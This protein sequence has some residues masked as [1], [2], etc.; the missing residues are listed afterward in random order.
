M[1]M[2]KSLL[3]DPSL[4]YCVWYIIQVEDNGTWS[5]LRKVSQADEYEVTDIPIASNA[6]DYRLAIDIEAELHVDILRWKEETLTRIT[7]EYEIDLEYGDEF[8]AYFLQKVAESDFDKDVKKRI[9][10]LSLREHAV[11]FG[12][13]AVI[14]MVKI[15]G[16]E[17]VAEFPVLLRM[18]LS[19][20]DLVEALAIIERGYGELLELASIDGIK[21]VADAGIPP[22][23]AVGFLN[24]YRGECEL[25]V[26]LYE[27]NPDWI[28]KVMAEPFV[29][30]FG[31]E[32]VASVGIEKVDM[33]VVLFAAVMEATSD[34]DVENEIRKFLSLS[35]VEKE[36]AI[37]FG[38]S[39]I[40]WIHKLDIPLELISDLVGAGVGIFPEPDMVRIND[41][42]FYVLPRM[43]DGA[44]EL[45][46][47]FIVQRIPGVRVDYDVETLPELPVE[48][49]A[50]IKTKH[51]YN[52]VFSFEDFLEHRADIEREADPFYTPQT[53]IR[54]TPKMEREDGELQV[55]KA[56]IPIKI[57]KKKQILELIADITITIYRCAYGDSEVLEQIRNAKSTWF[58]TVP[59][60]E[61]G[62]DVLAVKFPVIEFH[63][64]PPVPY[65]YGGFDTP[66]SGKWGRT[67]ENDTILFSFDAR[68]FTNIID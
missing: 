58:A 5:V 36:I 63:L 53:F 30:I 2:F 33:R 21:A 59:L 26:R 25:L 68:W 50:V 14:E 47:G 12:P 42:L 35:D 60:D 20:E 10:E 29:D 16:I 11:G 17:I 64:N 38:T 3:F 45:R 39:S 37:T 61:Y 4:G 28:T 18:M 41:K 40:E 32:R 51:G 24:R 27:L 65:W 1:F 9:I 43:F 56:S 66:P 49:L 55:L 22:D 31:L 48:P 54:V 8:D 34:V 52:V 6:E 44:D 19:K 62:N 7:A 13:E 46:G 23:I 15:A 57:L 67:R